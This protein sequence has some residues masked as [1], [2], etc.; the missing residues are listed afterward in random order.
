MPDV[1][2]IK[3]SLCQAA[4]DAY[5]D[6]YEKL[7]DIWKGLETKAQG[8]VTIAG[9]FIAGAFAFIRD[10]T[11]LHLNQNDKRL[12]GVAIFCLVLSV[13]L[14]ILVLTLRKVEPPPTGGEVSQAVRDILRLKPGEIAAQHDEILP[15]LN[16]DFINEQTIM[17][18]RAMESASKVIKW[19]V[20]SLWAA[21]WLLVV[22]ISLV[23][24]LTLSIV[25]R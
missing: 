14:S 2:E 3:E 18:R 16:L 6:E 25:A 4:L 9:I 1:Y 24:W 19:K 21:Q 17:W 22:A 12:L 23:V 11:T 10:L 20:K 7:T 5:H 13:I 8:V 15:E